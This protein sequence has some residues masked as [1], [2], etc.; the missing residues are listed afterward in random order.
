[1]GWT[2][3]DETGASITPDMEDVWEDFLKV[4]K[5]A[6]PFK[7][8][9]WVHLDKMMMIMP[10]TIKGTHVFRPPQGLSGVN[11]F[12]N[13]YD[14]VPN[15]QEE[16]AD[17]DENVMAE[18]STVPVPAVVCLFFTFLNYSL[19]LFLDFTLNSYSRLLQT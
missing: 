2:W 11:S 15:T 7:N 6:K 17:E 13:D 18:H 19:L 9:G 1:L 3:S 10:A 4:Y 14:D 5:E 8:H 16:E 12:P